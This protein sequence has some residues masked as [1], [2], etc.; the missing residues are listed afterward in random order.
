MFE[1]G[2]GLFTFY[3]D[4]LIL[5]NTNGMKV[6]FSTWRGRVL[7]LTHKAVNNTAPE[8]LCDLIRLNVKSTTIRTHAS[9]DPCLL[10]VPPISKTCA[11]SFFDRSFVYAAPTLWKALDL[12]IRLLL[13]HAL[14]KRVKTHLYLKYFAN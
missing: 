7:L 14:K 11:N 5:S 6:F 12:D 2:E 4:F 1:P 9:F 8:Y 13:F 10:C 3:S